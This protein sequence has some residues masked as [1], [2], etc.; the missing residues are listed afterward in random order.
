MDYDDKPVGQHTTLGVPEHLPESTDTNIISLPLD[1][2]LA[3]KNSKTRF[4]AAC[5]LLKEIKEGK[6][7]TDYT[8]YMH[9]LLLDSHPGV[10]EKALDILLALLELNPLIA[11]DTQTINDIIE[12]GITSSKTSIKSKAIGVILNIA[13]YREMQPMIYEILKEHLR[14]KQKFVKL[15]SNYLNLATELLSNFGNSIFPVK[16]ILEVIIKNA[17]STSAIVKNEAKSYLKEAY[18]WA[19]EEVIKALES[20]RTVEQEEFKKCFIDS[21]EP[22]IPKRKVKEHK[23]IKE[24]KVLA[25]EPLKK[26]KK[27]CVKEDIKTETVSDERLI[28]SENVVKE[29]VKVENGE[30]NL[31][32]RFDEEWCE[33]LLNAED[34]IAKRDQLEEVLNI[35]TRNNVK[36]DD[37]SNIVKAM[38]EL[39]KDANTKIVNLSLKVIGKLAL[40]L[41]DQ[42]N[43]YAKELFTSILKLNADKSI[44]EECLKNI[45]YLLNLKEIIE[46][47]KKL[48]TNEDSEVRSKTVSLII[49]IPNKDNCI[50]EL[51]PILIQL[52][53]D[54]VNEVQENALSCLSVFK[55]INPNEVEDLIKELSKEKQEKVMAV[56]K[57]KSSG[58]KNVVKKEVKKEIKIEDVGELMPQEE[59]NE[60][61]TNKVPSEIISEYDTIESKEKQKRLAELSK[62]LT[63]NAPLDDRFVE[64]L[65]LWI[66]Q[67][68]KDFKE[69]NVNIIGEAFFL[70]QTIANST[71]LTKK[72][73]KIIIPGIMEKIAEVKL[74]EQCQEL[75][76]SISD[77]ATPFYVTSLIIQQCYSLKGINGIK[78][79]LTLI[80]KMIDEYTVNLMPLNLILDYAKYNLSHSNIQIRRIAIKPITMTY[81]QLGKAI[82]PLIAADLKEAVYKSIEGE[83]NEVKVN[84]EVET[85]RKLK[86]LAESEVKVKSKDAVDSLMP[87]VNI[88]PQLTQKLISDIMDPAMKTRQEAKNTLEQILTSANNRILPNGL[89]S[90]M[91]ALK[92]RMNEPCKN[93]AKGFITLVGN[94]ATAL[95]QGFK[96]YSKTLLQPLM[97]NLA[98]KQPA[99][100]SET[101]IAIDKFAEAIG[102]AIVLNS[103]GPLLEKDNPDLRTEVLKWIIKNKKGLNAMDAN[104]LVGP[105]VLT[106][107]DRTKEIRLL[108]E[109]VISEL[110]QYV[111]YSA[112]TRAMQDLK[113]SVKSSLEVVLEKYKPVKENSNEEL[114]NN[115][116]K[117]V[118]AVIHEEEP[119]KGSE[120]DNVQKEDE[121]IQMNTL[122]TETSERLIKNTEE[123]KVAQV[124]NKEDNRKSNI[125]SKKI[126]TEQVNKKVEQSKQLSKTIK[127]W[128]NTKKKSGEHEQLTKPTKRTPTSAKKS[129]QVLQRPRNFN[130]ST[131]TTSI[132]YADL[133]NTRQ[134]RESQNKDSSPSKGQLSANTSIGDAIEIVILNPLGNKEKRAE[135]EKN[136]K[137][138]TYEIRK[139]HIE[140]LKKMLKSVMNPTVFEY[141]FSSELKKNLEAI[142]LL[143]EAI[144]CDITLIIDILDLIFKWLTM[145]MIEQGNLVINKKIIEHLSSL[146]EELKSNNYILMDFEAAVILPILCERLGI[147]NVGLK[148]DYK[149]LIK[150][151]F[152][153]YTP[154]K[155]CSYLIMALDSKNQ[156]TKAEALM[157]VKEYLAFNGHS[158]ISTKDIKLLVRALDESDTTIKNEASECLVE[159]YK[160]KG[161]RLWSLMDNLSDKKKKMLKS[162]FAQVVPS[163]TVLEETL[164]SIDPK[165]AKEE[166]QLDN[167]NK[168]EEKLITTNKNL[169]TIEQCIKAFKDSTEP[170]FDVLVSL[171]EQITKLKESNIEK[172][173][174]HSN[175]IFGLLANTLKS[176]KENKIPLKLKTY[177]L[178]MLH[179]ACSTQVLMKEA[180]ERCL[181]LL[182]EELMQLLLNTQLCEPIQKYIDDSLIELI[183][184]ADSNKLFMAILNLFKIHKEELSIPEGSSLPKIAELI[185]KNTLK[186]S[187]GLN[188]KEL[189]VC[190]VLLAMHEFLLEN[191]LTPKPRTQYDVIGIRLLKSIL[192]DLVKACKK[193]I[194][195]YYKESVEIHPSADRYLSRWINIILESI[196]PDDSTNELKAIFKGLKSKAT[197][198]EA[199]KKLSEHM[200]RYPEIKLGHYL[201]SCSRAFSQLIISSLREYKGKPDT[202]L[203]AEL[204]EQLLTIEEE[205]VEEKSSLAEYKKKMDLLSQKLGIVK[206]EGNNKEIEVSTAKG[207]DIMAKIN[208]Y[209]AIVNGDTNIEQ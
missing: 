53:D 142:R 188:L 145:K 68:L 47:I 185:I 13:E 1:E 121:S 12:K 135:A 2:R 70:L 42:F 164:S 34:W 32:S 19:K 102:P 132:S 62:W 162:K 28:E 133:P 90:L 146:F 175:D 193:D 125:P 181:C 99:I 52:A 94:L 199:I 36:A 120:E 30:Q 106:M 8:S 109:E 57:P 171:D 79:S 26:D 84:T 138:P 91:T 206:P 6:T 11:D 7:N 60:I 178:N 95:G 14:T 140:K 40:R 189:D 159:L 66:K 192:N 27:E 21:D 149:K 131:L 158:T 9:Q 92:S 55:L 37:I 136:M 93:I 208:K 22:P 97:W 75:T 105:L 107:Q 169:N 190:Q 154:S 156:K 111:G 150:I 170:N 153:I 39:L 4:E 186:F 182:M 184:N 81:S 82:K 114:D 23:A 100:R 74:F 195:K 197:F 196:K 160:H 176:I 104:S 61:V 58:K 73:A 87:R 117:E 174:A 24:E 112:F 128:K 31:F 143:T 56:K 69:N 71:Q 35:I 80:T 177:L 63:E 207:K 179:D 123:V 48:L 200:K 46:D 194:W 191:S 54:I 147:N 96:Q 38:K 25:K 166:I 88:A 152:G 126:S 116:E 204:R 85:K 198:N 172:L 78:N 167:D 67:K 209:K 165:V 127:D 148:N 202:E 119:D 168:E 65:A 43:V 187:K 129:T 137:W 49:N 44:T 15:T 5:E 180:S 130:P 86:G 89:S 45:S 155:V 41:R 201:A 98:D 77:S 76:L 203:E 103:F 157:T 59:A 110:M 183:M 115:T 64:A 141:M 20:L 134:I 163:E 161:E 33:N 101:V 16:E 113:P 51:G 10:Q 173:K 124:V 17:G 122:N 50:K 151:L 83:L 72:F 118:K 29:E 18:L 139:D 205:R 144:K 108:A 3:S